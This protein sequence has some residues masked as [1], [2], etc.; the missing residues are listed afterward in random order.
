MEVDKETE[1]QIQELQGLEK[2][3]QNILMQKQTF[4]MELTEV[5]NAI[6]ELGKSGDEAYKI[7]GNIMIKT[8]KENLLK[9]LKQKQDL[10]NLRLKSLNS[11]EKSLTET[12]EGLR[13]KILEKIQK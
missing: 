12:S 13:A 6:S 7:A 9:D 5:D 4:Q 11:Q 2:N 8:S 10:V 3:L 1:S